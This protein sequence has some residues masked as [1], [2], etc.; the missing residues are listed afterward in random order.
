MNR[1]KNLKNYLTSSS[2]VTANVTESNNIN[3]SQQQQKTTPAIF[4]VRKNSIDLITTQKSMFYLKFLHS[5]NN[6]TCCIFSR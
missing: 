4:S 3:G 2:P 6:V 5:K 1:F